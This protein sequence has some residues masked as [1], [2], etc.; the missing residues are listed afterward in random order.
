MLAGAWGTLLPRP[1][2][3]AL[4]R[5][6]LLESEAAQSSWREFVRS[7]DNPRRWIQDNHTG[8]KALLP[9]IAH[10]IQT[11]NLPASTDFVTWARMATLREELRQEEINSIYLV[12]SERLRIAEQRTL[13]MPGMGAAKLAWSSPQLRHNHALRLLVED[14]AAAEG[15]LAELGILTIHRGSHSLWLQH[16]TELSIELHNRLDPSFGQSGDFEQ[17]FANAHL[18]SDGSIGTMG[19]ADQLLAI[20]ARAA[21]GDGTPNLRWLVDIH[22]LLCSEPNWSERTEEIA[23]ISGWLSAAQLPIFGYALN[24]YLQNDFGLNLPGFENIPLDVDSMSQQRQ[25]LYTA[26][27]G[28]NRRRQGIKAFCGP[29]EKLRYLVWLLSERFSGQHSYGAT[30]PTGATEAVLT[31]G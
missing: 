13:L 6:C 4:L 18:V 29:L 7:V 3:R 8:L 14:T 9:F 5:A 26:L 10:K 20:I 28:V 21:S 2:E 11:N 27:A 31:N 22:A 24:E 17:A 23:Y 16:P 30:R 25:L 15:L 12:V 1:P 19:L